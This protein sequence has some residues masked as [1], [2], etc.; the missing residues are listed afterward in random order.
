[1]RG[2]SGPAGFRPMPGVRPSGPDTPCRRP[3]PA[4]VAR[5]L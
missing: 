5:G 4:L 3:L 1:M 2:I